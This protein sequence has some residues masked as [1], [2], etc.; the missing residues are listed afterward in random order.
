MKGVVTMHP[1]ILSCRY[2][3]HS[4]FAVE[5]KNTW[6]IFDHFLN[7][8]G[9]RFSISEAYVSPMQTEA[10]SFDDGIVNLREFG[11]KRVYIFISHSHSDHFNPYIYKWI[12][13]YKKMKYTVA[14]SI[15]SKEKANSVFAVVSPGETIKFDDLKIGTLASTDAGV[16]YLVEVDGCRIYHAGDHGNWAGLRNKM[17]SMPKEVWRE[18]IAERHL[19]YESEIDGLFE[20]MPGRIDLAFVPVSPPFT[21]DYLFALDTLA[22]DYDI[23]NVVPMHFFCGGIIEAPMGVPIEVPIGFPIGLQGGS[24]YLQVFDKIFACKFSEPYRDKIIRYSKRGEELAG[25]LGC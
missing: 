21:E 7:T 4:G 1:N 17:K 11:G 6:L 25:R 5:T 16:G 13:T 24:E 19:E 9:T 15:S 3:F 2:L 23:A 20:K 12:K 10:G 8:P 14:D 22:S 18:E